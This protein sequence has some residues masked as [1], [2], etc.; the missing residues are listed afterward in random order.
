MKQK[1]IKLVYKD[2]S[3]DQMIKLLKEFCAWEFGEFPWLDNYTETNQEE[4]AISLVPIMKNN[5][6]KKELVSK[7]P[8][9]KEKTFKIIPKYGYI[10][11]VIERL[12]EHGM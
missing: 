8:N 4:V 12:D 9:T 10:E 5:H 3:Y 7:D 11:T 2:I 6:V 1:N